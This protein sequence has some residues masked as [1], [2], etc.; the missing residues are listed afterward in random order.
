MS[1]DKVLYLLGEDFMHNNLKIKLILTLPDPLQIQNR[2]DLLY[3]E[4]IT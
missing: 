1:A 4:S 2:N 3:L